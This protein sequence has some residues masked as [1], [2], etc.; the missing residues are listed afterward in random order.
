M[1]A[2]PIVIATRAHTTGDSGYDAQKHKEAIA[3][4]YI[5]DKEIGL[6]LAEVFDGISRAHPGHQKKWLDLIDRC[7]TGRLADHT[8][9]GFLTMDM[10]KSVAYKDT[11][12]HAYQEQ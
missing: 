10:L 7:I 5:G 12:E 6:A 4:Y 11:E 3:D 8:E 9:F 2:D 1:S